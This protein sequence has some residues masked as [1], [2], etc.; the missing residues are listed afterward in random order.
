MLHYSVV[1]TEIFYG[2]DCNMLKNKLIGVLS[3]ILLM[4]NLL[5]A[6]ENP[7]ISILGDSYSTFA[8]AIP[9]NNAVWYFP[10]PN[11]RND[12][13]KVEQTWWH[14][15]IQMLGGELEKNESYSG[16]TV[17]NTGYN[18]SDAGRT[19]FLA[20][21]SRLGKPRIILVCGAT[22]DSWAGV[23]MG[24]YKYKDWTAKELFSFRPGL[25]KLLA[26]LKQ[27]YPQAEIYFILN[28]ELSAPI[29]E[30]V[31]T[32]CK[33]YDVPCLDLRNI[34]KQK[35][36]PDIAGMKAMAEQTAAFVRQQQAARK[37]AKP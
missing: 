32:I 36:H 31:H 13:C 16:S 37:Q 1:S 19:S 18:K 29:N 24:E 9:K 27:L 26:E 22:N 15:T 7:V 28:S 11:N 34:S 12:V 5:S 33:H 4:G 35:G 20:R 30:S 3:G 14:Q 6:D 2:K 25:A 21:A 17:C 23:P 10:A 8:G